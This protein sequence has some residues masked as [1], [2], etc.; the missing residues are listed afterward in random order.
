MPYRGKAS[1]LRE[2]G[3]ALGV[4]AILE[5]TVRRIGN[6]VRVNVQLINVEN[7]E[8]L[9]AED[10]DRDLTDVFAI[11]T[12][13]ARQIVRELQA[14]LSPME[15]A[16]IERKPTENSEAYLAF[17]QAHDLFTRMDKF[18]SNTERAEQLFEKRRNS[19]PTCRCVCR[20]GGERLD[21][22][23]PIH[24]GAQEKRVPS[25]DTIRLQPDLPSAS[26]ASLLYY[27]CTYYQAPRLI[28]NRKTKFANSRR[29]TWRWRIER[30][31]GKW[32]ESTVNLEKAAS[33]S[34]MDAWVLENLA[35]NYRANKNFETAEKLFDRAI[36]AAPNSLRARAQK[37]E[38]AVNWKGD[39]SVMEKE[40]A[41]SA[42]VDPTGS[43]VRRGCCFCVAEIPD[44]L[45]CASRNRL[46]ISFTIS[47]ENFLSAIY[48]VLNDK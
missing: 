3:K 5:G 43:S 20:I 28:G 15:K 38:L 35:H 12:D 2:I 30:R 26:R 36:A 21:E 31:Q 18:R 32:A 33:L 37:A 11:Q 8:H 7:D 14:K 1:N 29:F 40:V 42:S 47:Q 9:W 22:H 48:T 44:A 39:L 34:P 45:R 23:T 19:T 24:S 16:Q 10:Y 6:R 17:L 41:N 27:Y 46:N 13:L 25:G 4:G